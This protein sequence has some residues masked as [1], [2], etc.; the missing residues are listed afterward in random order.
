MKNC[1]ASLALLAIFPVMLSAQDNFDQRLLERFTQ[2]QIR[3]FQQNHPSVLAYWTYFLDHS[4]TIA[5]IPAQKAVPFAESISVANV[6]D[7]N[8]LAYELPVNRY[9]S[10]YYRIEGSDK[11]LILRSGQEITSG[12]NDFRAAQRKD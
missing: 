6:D 9:A 10:T 2:T 4:Y 11:F 5:D 7:F 8:I 12:F 1:I 3:D